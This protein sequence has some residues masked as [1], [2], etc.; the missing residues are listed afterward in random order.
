[1]YREDSV[2]DRKFLVLVTVIVMPWE[3][4][5][6]CSQKEQVN[7]VV[8]FAQQCVD[9]YRHLLCSRLC[10][11]GNLRLL[12]ASLNQLTPQCRIRVR[13]SSLSL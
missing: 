7:N 10:A 12:R 4:S 5:H 9:I 13:V 11:A 3:G 1:M 6:I 2:K 8:R